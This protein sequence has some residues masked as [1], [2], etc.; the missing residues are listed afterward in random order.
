MSTAEEDF[1]GWMLVNEVERARAED[2]T[3]AT[4]MAKAQAKRLGEAYDPPR[5]GPF[6]T[7]LPP[8]QQREQQRQ[9][10]APAP[11]DFSAL[12]ERIEKKGPKQLD[13]IGRDRDGLRKD[14]NG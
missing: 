10:S 14:L 5:H 6:D 7:R 11:A 4:D 1:P 13:L 2:P 3:F 8:R 9:S 12:L